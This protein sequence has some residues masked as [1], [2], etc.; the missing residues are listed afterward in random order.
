MN[1]EDLFLALT[2]ITFRHSQVRKKVTQEILDK[3]ALRKLK[4]FVDEQTVSAKVR[5][6][7]EDFYA[8][9]LASPP[10]GPDRC[11]NNLCRMIIRQC[12]RD[13]F[14]QLLT[15]N[16]SMIPSWTRIWNTEK[17]RKI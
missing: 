10:S 14:D 6:Y 16:P 7:A 2:W 11:C 4:Q 13:V 15:L 12:D 8:E 5:Q 1:Q 9:A 3:V 17:K